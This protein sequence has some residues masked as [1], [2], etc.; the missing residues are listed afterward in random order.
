MYLNLGFWKTAQTIDQACEAM[1]GLVAETARMGPDD[2]VVDVGFGFGDQDVL[3]MKRFAPRR[4]TGLNVTPSQV[5]I[6]RERVRQH[7][8]VDRIDLREGS[9]TDMPMAHS[10]CD[11]V[12]A[13]ECAFH[14][15]T[16]E[17]FFAEAFRV[18]RPGGRIV[19]ADMI[20][21]APATQRFQ[22]R[23]QEIAW[24][25]FARM[26]AVPSANADQREGY[27]KKLQ[28]AGF[29]EICVTSISDHVFPGWYR[30]MRQDPDLLRRIHL[31]G[32]LPLFG[33][34]DRLLLRVDTKAIYD[35]FDYVLAE[36]RKPL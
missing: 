1:A 2:D 21:A 35:T 10:S 14:F 28:A 12:T 29:A 5:Q 20:R 22:R 23:V 31:A 16:R 26:F 36:A 25:G 27:H 7:G 33:V 4:I 8:M 6:A 13:V 3:W 9:A 32:R 34:S 24:A 19:L 17:H 18:L 11:V 15:H 30:A